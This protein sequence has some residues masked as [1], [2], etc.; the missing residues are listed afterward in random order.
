[1]SDDPRIAD[2]HADESTCV[3]RMSAA[4]Q[5]GG[6]TLKP[7]TISADEIGQHNSKESFWAVIDGFVVDATDFVETHP[8]GLRKLLSADSAAAGASGQSFG[9]SFSRGR[10]AHF[11]RTAKL[12]KA[13]VQQFLRG[14]GS[15][16]S[17]DRGHLPPVAV[18]FAP[19]GRVVVLGCLKA[20]PQG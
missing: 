2:D 6:K 19:Y 3:E 9:F 15:D 20:Q 12:F 4:E 14:G 11:P 1:M 10:N 13:G 16:A 5:G 7:R 18:E 17:D 8:G